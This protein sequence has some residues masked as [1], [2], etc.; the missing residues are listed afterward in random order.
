MNYFERLA[1]RARLQVKPGKQPQFI[2]PFENEAAWSLETPTNNVVTRS[3]MSTTQAQPEALAVP[4]LRPAVTR[5]NALE[6]PVFSLP[7]AESATRASALPAASTTVP[8][9]PE[10]APLLPDVV[11]AEKVPT[12]VAPSPRPALEQA[13]VFMRSMG[14]ALPVPDQVAPPVSTAPRATPADLAPPAVVPPVKASLVPR[15]N[16]PV[17]NMPLGTPPQHEESP[18]PASRRARADVPHENVGTRKAPLAL[19]TTAPTVV[20]VS[21]RGSGVSASVGL[22][23]SSIGL[24]QL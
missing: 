4:L 5:S 14:V 15:L 17:P 2:D 19:S 24:G 18:P 12:L 3:E 11:P 22:G 9:N 23:H 1:R 7:K 21:A 13:D 6:P 16:P 10:L 20:V 8:A